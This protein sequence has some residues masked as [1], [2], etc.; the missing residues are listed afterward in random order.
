MVS[1]D[2]F[3]TVTALAFA[4]VGLRSWLVL[5]HLWHVTE[6]VRRN[7]AFGSISVRLSPGCLLSQLSW[8]DASN[9][10]EN[11]TTKLVHDPSVKMGMIGT[12]SWEMITATAKNQTMSGCGMPASWIEAEQK[13]ISRECSG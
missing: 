4:G 6:T 1:G 12:T 13:E 5:H 2:A 9:V 8:R 7:M 10:P 3:E 11:V